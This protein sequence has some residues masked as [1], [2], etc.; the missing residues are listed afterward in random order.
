[1]Y[2]LEVPQ[3]LAGIGIRGH[4][5]GAKQ[6]RADTVRTIAIP[7]RRAQRHEDNSALH[8]DG[9]KSPNIGA[10]SLPPTIA[11]P[12]VVT[13]FSGTRYRMK[14]PNRFAC[15]HIPGSYVTIRAPF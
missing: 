2:D 15:A 8:V 11:R 4:D 10:G 3:A 7:A 12:T 1:M 5:G 6:I 13:I 14:G 9:W